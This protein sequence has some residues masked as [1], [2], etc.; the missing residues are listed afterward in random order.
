MIQINRIPV[1][2]EE[3][4]AMKNQEPKMKKILSA[5]ERALVIETLIIT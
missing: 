2:L 3:D 1:G 5:E 4:I